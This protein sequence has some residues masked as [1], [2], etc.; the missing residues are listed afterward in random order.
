MTKVHYHYTVNRNK[1]SK[2]NFYKYA[3]I[4]LLFPILI[5]CSEMN[6]KDERTITYQ[7]KAHKIVHEMVQKVGTLQQLKNKKD[8]EY[9]YTYETPNHQKDVSKEKY[10]FNGEHSY[11]NYILH[12]RTIPQLNGQIEQGFNGQ[13]FWLRHNQTYIDSAHVIKRVKFN[14]KTNYYW[15]TMFQKLMDPGLKYTFLGDTT[16]N[17]NEYD[18]VKVGFTSIDD[19]PTDIYQLYINKTTKLV[20]QFLFTVVDFGLVDTPMLMCVEY[21]NIEGLLIPTKRKYKK[22]TWAATVDGKPWT[23]V[24][25]SNIKFNVGLFPAL[26]KK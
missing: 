16:I 11:G 19:K 24:Q 17:N 8:V 5:S 26:F 10:I 12:Q 25:W 18:V 7:N 13:D 3:N 22:S 4:V 9:L 20:D 1:M 23:N 21:E 14:R 2:M 6:K 15:F